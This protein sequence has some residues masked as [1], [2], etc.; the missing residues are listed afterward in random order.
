[1]K[2]GDVVQ[3]FGNPMTSQTPLGQVTL[4]TFLQETEHMELWL[5]E[6]EDQPEYFY[7]LWLKKQENGKSKQN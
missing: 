3:G 2:P 1:M 4:K 7:E 6:Y 5:V